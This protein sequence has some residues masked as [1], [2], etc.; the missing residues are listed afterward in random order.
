[1]PLPDGSRIQGSSPD[2][3]IQ[4]KTWR[5]MRIPAPDGLA[6]KTVLDV[7]ANDGYYSLAALVSGA[8]EVVAVNCI[9]WGTFPDN[10]HHAAQPWGLMPRL[11]TVVADFRT[12][13]F[14]R[15]FDVI[16]FL[17]V[18]YHLEDPFTAT[19]QLRDL[20]V[21]GGVMYVETQMSLID[22]PLPVFEYASDTYPTVAIQAKQNL[23]LVGMSDYLFPNHHAM[24]NLA[25]SY[26]FRA[27]LLSTPDTEFYQAGPS[28]GL[29]KFTRLG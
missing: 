8:A 10:I 5:A 9:D 3:N 29:Y 15:R 21:E 1:M 14:D 13:R 6:G 25:H 23:H 17:G 2:Q 4:L 12:H 28:R 22:S 26:D 18:L 24:L 16:F 20:L 11:K 19:R 7:G 27:E